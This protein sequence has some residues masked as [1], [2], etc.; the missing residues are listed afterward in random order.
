MHNK[1]HTI[2]GGDHSAGNHKM[3]HSDGSGALVE[4]ALGA[5]GTVLLGKGTTVAPAFGTQS[6]TIGAVAAT[7]SA[8]ALN[9]S[10][11]TS[12]DVT[13]QIAT[14][15]LNFTNLPPAG[16]EYHVPMRILQDGTGGRT[17]TWGLNG[18]P[19]TPKYV[20]GTAPTYTT[21]AGSRDKLHVVVRNNEL[22]VYV[23][24]KDLK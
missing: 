4:I 7:T 6:Y 3:F 9:L 10:A 8:T 22:E 5:V 16:V 20:G 12:F 19:T 1:T 15:Q 11:V 23:V 17:F 14:T 13:L 2:T 18:T 21:V 24:A